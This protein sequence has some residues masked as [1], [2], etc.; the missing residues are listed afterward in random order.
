LPRHPCCRLIGHLPV[1]AAFGPTGVT[2]GEVD[3]V[4]M[5]LDEFEAIRLAD[6]QDLYQEDAAVRMEVSRATFGRI[7]RSARR[8]LAEVLT[9]GLGL[10]IEGGPVRCTGRMRGVCHC[11][12]RP[13][14]PDNCRARVPGPGAREGAPEE[15][16]R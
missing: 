10:R 11:G 14:G 13:G 3:E 12:R 7:L 5:T 16:T 15:R 9:H 2:G 1:T 8:K 4:V 6:H